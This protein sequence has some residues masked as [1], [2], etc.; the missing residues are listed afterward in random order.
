MRVLTTVILITILFFVKAEAQDVSVEKSIWGVQAGIF[1]LS[2]YNESRLSDNISLRSEAL[3][4]FELWS[5]ASSSTNWAILPYINI[6]PRW[7][8]NLQ[9]RAEKGKQIENN[10]GNYFSMQVISQPGFGISST[11]ANFN[12][13]LYAIPTYGLRRNI[14]KHF[15]FET[16][17]GFGY[18][19]VFQEYKKMDGSIYREAESGTAYSIR[20][21]IGYVF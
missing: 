12:P 11:N 9:K 15:N 20:L 18:G 21:T 5:G 14:N 19:C 10:N 6:E 7:Y 3:L 4:G 16:A 8:Y 17:I 2:V 1:P 13:G